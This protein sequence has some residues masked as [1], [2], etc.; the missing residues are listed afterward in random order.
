MADPKAKKGAPISKMEAVRRILAERGSDTMPTEIQK[1]VKERF[2]LPITRDH[3]SVC[4]TEIRR[5]EAKG[6]SSG[7]KQATKEAAP[8]SPASLAPAAASPASPSGAAKTPRATL[9]KMDA[10]RQAM[11]ALGKDAQPL[12]IQGFL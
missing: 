4:K 2:G 5:Q 3:V 12:A 8:R 10:M 6:A 7:Q 9:T 1:L 11:S